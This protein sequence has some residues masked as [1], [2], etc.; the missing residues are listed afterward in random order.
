MPTK[1]V[2]AADLYNTPFKNELAVNT[3]LLPDFNVD[4]K[5]T[6]AVDSKR[7]QQGLP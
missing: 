2:S 7:R 4:I 6:L 3:L 1:T 5:V